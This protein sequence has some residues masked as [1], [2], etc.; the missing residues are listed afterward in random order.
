MDE[1]KRTAAIAEAYLSNKEP[2]A[3]VARRYKMT[4]RQARRTLA[5]QGYDLDDINR[6]VSLRLEGFSWT[7]IALHVGLSARTARKRFEDSG[8]E[9]PMPPQ[10]RRGAVKDPKYIVAERKKGRSVVEIALELG[11]STETVYTYLRRAEGVYLKRSKHLDVA[12]A[13]KRLDQGWS[14]HEICSEQGI[15]S[16]SH[17]RE[18]MRRKGYYVPAGDVM[19]FRS[20]GSALLQLVDRL[21]NEPG[22]DTGSM[23]DPWIQSTVEDMALELGLARRDK[24]GALAVMAAGKK[25]LGDLGGDVEVSDQAVRRLRAI[26]RKRHGVGARRSA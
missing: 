8:R 26:E 2:M 9:D 7:R 20:C 14:M 11:V 15:Q 13:A 19:P 21:V 5:L 22:R 3:D 6:V 25:L 12:K 24:D 10:F 23:F 16:V 4:P 1:A 17:A 18:T